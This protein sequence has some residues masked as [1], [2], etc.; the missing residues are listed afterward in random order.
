[1]S[2]LIRQ[3][4]V[5]ARVWG[6]PPASKRKEKAEHFAKQVRAAERASSMGLVYEAHEDVLMLQMA[7]T[8]L[9]GY[10]S[11][12]GVFLLAVAVSWLWSIEEGLRSLAE[13][14]V[15][16][17][18]A[19]TRLGLSA[20][21]ILV[22]LAA[23]FFG[24]RALRIDLLSPTQIPLILN[25]K[26]RKVY[27]VVQADPVL[28]GI[29]P[30]KLLRHWAS[31]FKPW[32]L[33]LIEYDWDCLECEYYETTTLAGNVVKH[34][35]YLQLYVRA[36][37]GSEEVLG[38]FLLLSP[39]I[40]HRGTALQ[41]WEHLRRF[42]EEGGPHLSPGDQPAPK[43][44][45]TPWA[46]VHA[47]MSWLWPVVLLGFWWGGKAF[48]RE[49]VFE[50]PPMEFLMSGAGQRISLAETGAAF[51]CTLAVTFAFFNWIAHLIAPS[52]KLPEDILGGAGAR[53]SRE[54]LVRQGKLPLQEQAPANAP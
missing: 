24:L 36:E 43:L 13:R 30:L 28:Q 39:M 19:M 52:L 50:M 51:F 8:Y 46:A 32:P 26:T 23:V 14:M 41:L 3:R 38:S 42:M 40:T 15:N 1:M 29:G 22:F 10:I 21:E 48:V 6:E 33:I 17:G 54:E 2:P 4:A 45:R 16:D 34:Y 20:A 44:P 37:P 9:R 53:L 12:F 49:G 25:R 5:D 7:P 35:N 47:S 18:A 27:R 31:V 11:T